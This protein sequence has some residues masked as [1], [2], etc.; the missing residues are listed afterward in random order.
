MHAGRGLPAAQPDIPGVIELFAK[1][2]ACYLLGSIVGSLLVGRLRGVDLRKV[3][4][5]NPGGTNALRT[6]GSAFAFWVML[7]DL[8]KGYL[9]ARVVGPGVMPGIPAAAPTVRLWL[10]EACAAA[11]MLGHIYPV[12]HGFRGGKG[13]ATLL[14]AVSGINA[15][16]LPPML[17]TWLICVAVLGFVGLGSMLGAAALP[18][19]VAARAVEPQLPL[20]TFGVFATLLIAFTHRANI[21]RMREGREP[22]AGRLWLLGRGRP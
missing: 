13:V 21:G 8:G 5:G 17:L 10:P 7:I 11:A 9:A 2:T 15:W 20:L 1:V 19:W 6:Q 3:G 4:S 12:W 22:R 14:G 16:L 18:S